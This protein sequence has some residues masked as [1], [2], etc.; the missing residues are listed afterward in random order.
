MVVKAGWYVGYEESCWTHV[1]GPIIDNDIGYPGS[2][3]RG[4]FGV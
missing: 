1:W 3:T 2:W 4:P